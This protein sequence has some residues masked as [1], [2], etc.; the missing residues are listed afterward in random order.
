LTKDPEQIV[1]GP[2]TA[3]SP[4]RGMTPFELTRYLDY[5]TELLAIISKVAALYVQELAD[6]VT[7]DAA[8][9]VQELAV[10]LSTTIWQKIVILDRV[11][12]PD[13]ARAAVE[14]S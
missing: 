5:S 12:S 8:S 9:A 13:A 10:N 14:P 2:R 7:I 6:P 4:E 11:L 3:S 1:A